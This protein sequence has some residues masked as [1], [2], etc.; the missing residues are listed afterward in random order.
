MIGWLELSALPWSPGKRKNL[1]LD[2]VQSL[3]AS[4]PISP[5]SVLK[6]T[7]QTMS[8]VLEIGGNPHT[9][10]ML[11]SYVFGDSSCAQGLPTPYPLLVWLFICIL[12]NNL[13]YVGKFPEFMSSRKLSNIGESGHGSPQICSQLGRMVPFLCLAFGTGL[14][15]QALIMWVVT[16]DLSRIVGYP[17]DVERTG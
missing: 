12:C 11:Y 13:L 16:S 9:K 14:V 3:V 1:P 5:N 15:R 2:R 10:R 17:I 6:S 7:L 4:D 8:K